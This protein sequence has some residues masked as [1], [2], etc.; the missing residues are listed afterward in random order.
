MLTGRTLDNKVVVFEGIMKDVGEMRKI[1][2]VKNNKW[3]LTGK[4]I[5]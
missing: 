4:I 2:I 5:K 3:Y 1:K